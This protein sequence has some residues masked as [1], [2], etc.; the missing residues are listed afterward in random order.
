MN[1]LEVLNLKQNEL[2]YIPKEIS[3]LNK[4]ICLNLSNNKFKELPEAIGELKE[5]R[6]LHISFNNMT[7]VNPAI[8]NCNNL[9]ADNNQLSF[10]LKEITKQ[11]KQKTL[12]LGYNQF[13]EFETVWLKLTNL[14]V[15]NL[16]ND[17]LK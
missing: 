12:N 7:R 8:K 14:K 2:P 16:E 10:L 4:F 5:L 1:E 17:K 6:F 13:H 11:K 9:E 3:N 15:L